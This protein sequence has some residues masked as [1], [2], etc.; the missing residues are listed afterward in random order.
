MPK[1]ILVDEMGIPASLDWLDEAESSQPIYRWLA[2]G[3]R[4]SLAESPIRQIRTWF[5]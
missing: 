5:C 2:G 3:A 4:V 1:L